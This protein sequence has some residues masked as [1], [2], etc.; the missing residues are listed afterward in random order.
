[1]RSAQP[2]RRSLRGKAEQVR[3]VAASRRSS[4]QTTPACSTAKWG[5]DGR[6]RRDGWQPGV[7]AS[8]RIQPESYPGWSIAERAGHERARKDRGSLP[9]LLEARHWVHDDV[10]DS[11]L[12][13]HH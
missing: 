13:L 1:M 3:Y 7:G 8:P 11:I 6:L 4:V 2:V 10:A 5:V 12:A 9:L